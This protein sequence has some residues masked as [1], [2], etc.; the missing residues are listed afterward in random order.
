M[1]V[2]FLFVRELTNQGLVRSRY[3]WIPRKKLKIITSESMGV[4]YNSLKYSPIFTLYV[5]AT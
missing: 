1:S 2:C 3:F 4:Q 5:T